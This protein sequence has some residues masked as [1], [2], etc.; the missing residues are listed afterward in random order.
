MPDLVLDGIPFKR[1]WN[2]AGARGFFG[3]GY[4]WHGPCRPLGLD[5]RGSTFV[6]K[7]TTVEPRAGNMPLDAD[8]R[9]RG[10]KP[11]CIKVNFR[12]AAV[13]NAVGLSGPGLD[14][15]LADGRWQARRDPF[16]ISFMAV[17][18]TPAERV[19]KAFEFALAVGK[20]KH[21]FVAPFGVQV[22]LSCLPSWSRVITPKGC[23]RII[24]LPVTGEILSEYGRTTHEGVVAR[25]PVELLRVTTQTGRQLYATPEHQVRILDEDGHLT[26]SSIRSLEP[27]DYLLSRR[28]D[29][30]VPA[31][32]GDRALWFSIGYF[33]GDGNLYRSRYLNWGFYG[34]KLELRPRIAAL[35]TGLGVTPSFADLE[36]KPLNGKMRTEHGHTLGARCPEVDCHIPPYRSKGGWRAS[37]IPEALWTAGPEAISGFLD[38]LLSADGGVPKTGSFIS[39]TTKYRQ[40]VQDV[41]RLLLSVGVVSKITPVTQ[42]TPFGAQRAYVLRTI[43]PQSLKSFKERV[44]FT[45]AHKATLLASAIEKSERRPREKTLGYHKAKPVLARIFP[46][47]T[48]FGGKNTDTDRSTTV[49]IGLIRAGKTNL[50]A[51]MAI[52][53]VLEKAKINGVVDADFKNLK[54]YHE[55][56]WWFDRVERVRPTLKTYPVFDVIQSG[57]SSYVNDGF[58]SHNCPNVDHGGES[59]REAGEILSNMALLGVP[60]VP[61]F[62]VD[63]DVDTVRKIALH[64]LVSAIEVSNTLK[65]GRLPDRVD[66]AGLFGP[67]SPLAEYGGGG[68]SGAPLLPI[69]KDWVFRAR[70][71][72]ITRP[73]ILGGG[74]MNRV[75]ALELSAWGSSL[76]NRGAVSIGSVAILRPWRVRGIIRSLG[77]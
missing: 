36:P 14:V 49:T 19:A 75:D 56:G 43:G 18:A 42:T 77:A 37:G 11:A 31:G 70:N 46:S 76:V 74:V 28:G 61:K 34:P 35:L 69:V 7:T 9:P 32:G 41:Q 22:N 53:R 29:G 30:G 47:G 16:F 50:I 17:D 40:L 72:G 52:P 71:Q 20:E 60:L 33:Y 68:L 58:V 57:T 25:P 59:W 38:G 5:W 13:L 21:R 44:G 51:G 6:A 55:Q 3:E 23:V 54:D 24:D 65:W 67:V 73:L 10:L 64:P 66:W 27:G 2:A 62:A 12:K 15:L 8:H 4:W 39:F 1:A 45:L 63:A 48:K 26:W